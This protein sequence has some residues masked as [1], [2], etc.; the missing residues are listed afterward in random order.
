MLQNKFMRWLIRLTLML[1]LLGAYRYWPKPPLYTGL[2]LSKVVLSAQGQLLHLSLASDER[3]RLWLPLEQFAPQLIEATLLKEDRW[4]YYHPGVNPYRLLLATVAS[5]GGDTQ[6]AS[7]LTM[8]LARMKY[9]LYTRTVWGKLKQIIY[10]LRLEAGYSKRDLLEAYLNYA[11]YGGNIEGAGTA[12]LIYFAKPAAQLSLPEALTLAVLPQRPAHRGPKSSNQS[13]AMSPELRA[14]RGNLQALWIAAHGAVD[15]ALFSAPLS[16]AGRAPQRAPHA[17]RLLLSKANPATPLVAIRSTIDLSL[18]S[19][20]ERQIASYLHGASAKGVHNAAA[21]LLDRRDMT[22]RALVGS[23]DFFNAEIRG[24]VDGTQAQR[25]PGSTLK[26]FIYALAIDQGLLQPK[27]VLADVPTSYGSF[28]P[29]NFDGHFRGPITATDALVRSRNIPAVRIAA[30]LSEHGLFG[31]LSQAGIRNLASEGHYGL[32]LALGGGEVSPAELAALYAMLGNDG[33]WRA[34]RY[35]SSD[36]QSVGLPLLSPEAAFITRQMLYHNPRPRAANRSI[37][38]PVAWKTGTS[39]SFRDAWSAGIFGQFV[40][41]LWVGNFDGSGN[42]AFIGGQIAAPLFFAISDDLYNSR[43]V[44]IASEN[45]AG[46][47]V[48]EIDVCA[49]SGDLP[50]ADCPVRTKTWFIPGV[51]PIRVSDVHRR[52][53][54]DAK[55]G[56]PVCP[57]A[58]NAHENSLPTQVMEFWPSEIAESFAAAGLKLKSAPSCATVHA[59]APQILSPISGVSFRLTQ[60]ELKQPSLVLRASAAAGVQ[61]LF[62]FANSSFVGKTAPG[63]G[64]RFAPQFA[65]NIQIAVVDDLGGRAERLVRVA[66]R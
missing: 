15:E 1:A 41:V 65:R 55:T 30:K 32:S 2:P 3:Y 16:I 54:I 8:Q 14:A 4:F 26:P 43:Q 66:L 34:L 64:L 62:W 47:N 23:A 7:T 60:A 36:A 11:P 24:Q 37:R 17:A 29:E 53:Y 61:Q 46:L 59:Q 57:D 31:L 50:N 27:T 52:V 12:S 10:A 19:I 56:A 44:Q 9:G 42:P 48:S 13:L 33:R 28:A 40:L 51:S 20:L 22:V 58:G 49:A 35:L 63:E 38:Y 39:W 6:G 25:S 21:I 45:S 18:Q 5:A